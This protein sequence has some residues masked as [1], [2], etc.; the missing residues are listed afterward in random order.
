LFVGFFAG[1]D[2]AL[3][4]TSFAAHLLLLFALPLHP[5]KSTL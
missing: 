1:A 3:Y 5:K 4:S 2:A